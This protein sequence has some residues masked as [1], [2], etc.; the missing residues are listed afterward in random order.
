[1]EWILI[2][3]PLLF[4]LLGLFVGYWWGKENSM[5]A[6]ERISENGT[7]YI[8]KDIVDDMLATAE[9]HAYFA[10]SEN[11]KEKLTDAFIEKACRWL[12]DNYPYYFE[13]DIK[14]EFVKAMKGG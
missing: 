6:P 8:R 5:E 11:A 13:T 4:Y 2:F 1:M 7:E 10:G 14:E 12:E 9:D 3:E